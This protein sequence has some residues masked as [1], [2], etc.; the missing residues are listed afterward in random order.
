[1][2][3]MKKLLLVVSIISFSFFFLSVAIA[4]TDT[5]TPKESEIIGYLQQ[6]LVV[7]LCFHDPA[8]PNLDKIK[9]DIESVAANFKGAVKGVYVSGDDKKETKLRGNFKMTPKDTAVFILLPPG[10][11]VAKLEGDAITKANLM[12]SLLSA[13]GGG[14]CGSSCK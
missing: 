12:R 2:I 14:S 6:G 3:K 10:T 9:A 11:A 13:C 5:K 1:M 8:E 4:E 7:F